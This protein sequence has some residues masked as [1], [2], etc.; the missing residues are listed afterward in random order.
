MTAPNN[1]ERILPRTKDRQRIVDPSAMLDIAAVVRAADESQ[2]QRHAMDLVDD[3]RR[4][5]DREVDGDSGMKGRKAG[6]DF[7]HG[8]VGERRGG[9]QPQPLDV[10][11]NGQ[12]LAIRVAGLDGATGC[13]AIDAAPEVGGQQVAG[14]EDCRYACQP[15]P[16]T[17][18]WPSR[19]GR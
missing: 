1:R 4:R 15:R 2:V 6:A 12:L 7:R 18:F 13:Q 10:Y 9:S 14:A 19:P 11:R 3:F 5:P 16:R 8:G 17:G